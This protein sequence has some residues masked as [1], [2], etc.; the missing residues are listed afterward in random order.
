MQSER[1]VSLSLAAIVLVLVIINSLTTDELIAEVS[2][3]RLVQEEYRFPTS[4]ADIEPIDSIVKPILYA[5][6]NF[7]DELPAE[8]VKTS[9]VNIMVPAILIAKKEIGFLKQQV[10][11]LA[12]K[13]V[14]SDLDSAFLV[15]LMTDYR[16]NSIEQLITRMHTH[17]TSIV[18]GQA[19]IESGWGRSRFFKEANNVFGV[20]SM[21]PNEDRIPAKIQR[22]DRQV[23]L[24]SYPDISASIKDYF[25]TI[26]KVNAYKSFRQARLR[27]KDYKALIPYLDKYSERGEDYVDDLAR[28]IRFNDFERYDSY[29]LDPNFVSSAQ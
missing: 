12:K 6:I 13:D 25:L 24:K 10:E 15:P 20:W 18:L 28:M 7:L 26:G 16:A 8:E 19:A 29:Q 4:A 2:I 21:N 27:S 23:Y 11:S 17:P 3:E 9:F 1:I 22:T 14:L 5:D